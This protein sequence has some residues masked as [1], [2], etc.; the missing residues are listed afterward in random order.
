M[1]CP[2]CQDLGIF[3]VAYH[4][5]PPHFA[6]CLCRIGETWRNARNNGRPTNP[7]WHT[8]A[9][10]H[11]VPFDRIVTLEDYA[12]AEELAAF[13]FRELTAPA[14]ALSAIASAARA[15]GAKLR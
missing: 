6:L 10:Q 2:A 12:T 5:E 7:L 9:A 13:G 8:W 15:R 4:G 3:P 11:Q 14:D 1:S